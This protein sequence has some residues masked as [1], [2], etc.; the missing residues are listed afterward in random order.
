MRPNR[1]IA[2][3]YFAR[4]VRLWLVVRAAASAV[5]LAGQVNPIHL[6]LA[7]SI[8]LVA[9]ATGVCFLDTLRLRERAFLGNLGVRPSALAVMFAVPAIVGEAA[10]RIAAQA[11]S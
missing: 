9:F 3:A 2:R 10:I 5:L 7:S 11:L 8:Q 4:G 1:V 6:P